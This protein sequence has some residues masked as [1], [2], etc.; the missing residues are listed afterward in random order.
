MNYKIVHITRYRYAEEVG[1]CHN[2]AR[3]VPYH[4]DRQICHSY[5][6][7]ID[8]MSSDYRER[9]DF[10]GNK[11]TYFSIHTSHIE[12]KVTATSLVETVPPLKNVNALTSNSPAWEDVA[13]QMAD[14]RDLNVLNA[15][16]FCYNSPMITPSQ[17]MRDYALQSFTNRR[18]VLEAVNDLVARIHKDFTYDAQFT[19]IATPL[20]DVFAHRRGVCQDFAH[21]AIA[22][23]RSL[24]LAAR[25]V[26]GYIETIP[27]E[28]Q[29]R[30]IGADASHAWFSL[31]IPDWDWIDFDPTN[32]KIADDQHIILAIG[33]DYQD[34]TPLKG[35]LFGGGKHQLDVSVDVE[36]MPATQTAQL[37]NV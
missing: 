29:A 20:Q 19:T 23:L 31:Y 36:R 25:Y 24:G 16:Q 13:A 11:V 3:L 34:V 7:D 30:L 4:S 21:L 2:E 14:A 27:P 9:L 12:L 15:Q 32:N 26:S 17:E 10:F 37:E 28:G 8:P 6:I 18:P 33:R 22:C 1:S 35:V 5:A